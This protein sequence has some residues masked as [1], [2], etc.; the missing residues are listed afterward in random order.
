MTTLP[1]RLRC[2][3]AETRRALCRGVGWALAAALLDGACGVLLVPLIR[4][5]FSGAAAAALHWAIALGALTLCHAL[6][7][8]AAQLRGYRAGGALAAGLVERLVRHLPRVA[9]WQ[10]VRDSHPAGLLRGP[11][12]QAMGIPAHLLGP[13]IGA[14]ATPLAVVAGLACIDWRIALCLAAA[15]AL[16]FALLER[17]GARTLAL[18]AARAA[19]DRDVAA[20]LQVFAAH[21]GLLRFADQDGDARAALQ[22]ALDER[23][24]SAR[25]LMRRSLPIE[26]GFAGAVQA[27]FVAMLAG[28]AWAVAHERLDAA[29]AVA[30]L[31]L[32]V[33]FI[34]PLAQLTQLDQAL[35]G[36]WRALDAVLGV[37]DASRFESP[38]HGLQ[39]QD[40]SVEAIRVGCRSATGAALL[41]GVDLHCP[42]GGFVAIVGP[43]GAG[44]STLLG[45]LGRLADPSEGCV[46][47]GRADVRRL[48][49]TTLAAARHIAFQD[50]GLFRGSLAWNLRM[51]CPEATDA[52]LRA[53]L[54]AV[55]LARDVERLPHGLETDV[56]PGGQ[57]LSGGQRQRACLARGLLAKAPVLLLDEP[58]ASLDVLS[59]R[60]VRD[61]LVAMRGRRTRIVVT[62][63]PALAREADAIVVLDA[64][65]VRATGT[66]AQLVATDA[67]YAT[68]A[69]GGREHA[70]SP[71]VD[72]DAHRSALEQ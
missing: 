69:R 34:E 43:T 56:G 28:G 33:R 68:F 52:E 29:T 60:R 55:G 42:A 2:L 66:H 6:V 45:L 57:L 64:G 19:G 63:Q 20:Q 61:S 32:L 37:L 41:D 1:K 5:W 23:H 22:R 16:L 9:S 53:A 51:S 14:V 38:E 12:L 7:L 59:A 70:A 58:T 36:G 24:R 4:A 11:V 8:Y 31:V 71:R 15:A 62:H 35:R 67:W 49:E 17:G 21:Q 65:R 40:A 54:Q 39:V 44:K 27:V 48:S 30:V 10:T 50:N 47:L 18:E 13:L 25:A 26:L 46:R 3:P 72:A